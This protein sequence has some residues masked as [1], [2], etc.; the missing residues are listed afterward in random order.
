V[1]TGL[2]ARKGVDGHRR[3]PDGVLRACE[4]GGTGMTTS[5]VLRRHGLGLLRARFDVCDATNDESK[6]RQVAL[7]GGCAR[8]WRRLNHVDHGAWG[9]ARPMAGRTA[10][11]RRGVGGSDLAKQFAV[12]G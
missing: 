4:N 5:V 12:W 3:S 7:R 8:C 6:A 10:V 11:A 2:C 1:T 9:K